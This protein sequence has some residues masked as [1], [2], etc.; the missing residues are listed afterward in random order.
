MC[1]KSYDSELAYCPACRRD[2]DASAASQPAASQSEEQIAEA[3]GNA[4]RREVQALLASG[5]KIAAIKF[6]RERTGAGLAEAKRAV[7]TNESPRSPIAGDLEPRLLALLRENK[8]IEAIRAYREA[9]NS[10]LKESKDAVD[11][12]A[13]EHGIAVKGAGC[14]ALL[15]FAC[16]LGATAVAAGAIAAIY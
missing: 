1:G 15:L 6:Y 3:G 10:G 4:W 9:T 12:L 2:A 13:R 11:A 16:T 14:A 8:K 7:E 5:E